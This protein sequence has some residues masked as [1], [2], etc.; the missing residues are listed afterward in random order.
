MT[1]KE[2]FDYISCKDCDMPYCDTKCTML[3]D[4]ELNKL[5]QIADDYAIEFADWL[6]KRQTNYFESLKQLL[7]V[8][9][10]EKGL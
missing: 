4:W 10:K 1:L 3:S 6:I 5:E 2:K 8:F 9:K 7:E